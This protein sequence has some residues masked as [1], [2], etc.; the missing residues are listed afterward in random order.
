MPDGVFNVV[1]GY[2]TTTG[3]SLVEHPLVDKIDITVGPGCADKDFVIIDGSKG[4]HKRRKSAWCDRWPEAQLLYCG[5]RW[6]GATHR[7]WYVTYPFS[8]LI[9]K[10]IEG[11]VRSVLFT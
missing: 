1:T 8:F 7:V 11:S 4:E 2:G 10:S 5:V 3:K 6:Q 9:L